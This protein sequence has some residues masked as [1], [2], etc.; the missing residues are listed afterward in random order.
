MR[1]VK[2]YGL[3]GSASASRVRRSGVAG[4]P[5]K[6]VL[7]MLLLHLPCL[8]GIQDMLIQY[9]PLGVGFNTAD[10]SLLF[11]LLGAANLLV[12][13][14]RVA[15]TERRAYGYACCMHG[16]LLLCRHTACCCTGAV[17]YDATSTCHYT[18][19]FQLLH[20]AL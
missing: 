16:H 12:Q 3:C 2:D 19:L 8:Q 11:T 18:P 1:F 17:A 20:P 4:M 6:G 14:R 5:L 10:Q 9:L 15:A 7:L 13:V